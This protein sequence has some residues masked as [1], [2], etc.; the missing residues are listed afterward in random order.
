MGRHLILWPVFFA[1]F[2]A[3]HPPDANK[4]A[5]PTP[6][7]ITGEILFKAKQCY[8][9]HTIGGGPLAGPDLK[10][11]FSRRNEAWVRNYISDPVQMAK[12]D[13]IARE[14]KAAYKIQM[15]RLYLRPAELDQ[16]ILYLQS[17]T[18]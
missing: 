6:V 2:C 10:G 15:P 16:L 4:E 7:L 12:T 11:L 3:C 5:G 13:P 1:F 8:S 9:C 18:R 14:L 17:S